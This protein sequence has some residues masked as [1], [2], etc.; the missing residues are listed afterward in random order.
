MIDAI[1]NIFS[2]KLKELSVENNRLKEELSAANQRIDALETYSKKSNLIITGI[3]FASYA[4]SASTQ[5]NQGGVAANL[6]SAEVTENAFLKIVNDQLGVNITSSDISL[7]HRL[8]KSTKPGSP[9]AIIVRFTNLKARDRVYRARKA[10]KGY[11]DSR[12]YINEDLSNI[13]APVVFTYG[14]TGADDDPF[15]FNPLHELEQAEQPPRT[16]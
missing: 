4:E 7:A 5:Q 2:N 3:P 15:E 12:I 11:K 16:F 14:S 6:E 8:P 13:Y 1:G 9:S 10:L